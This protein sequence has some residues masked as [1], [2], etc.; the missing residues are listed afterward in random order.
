MKKLTA[1]I[2]PVVLLAV[3]CA[4]Q[5]QVSEQTTTDTSAPATATTTTTPAAYDANM[6]FGPDKVVELKQP[7]SNKVIIKLMF[8][9]GSMVDP[10]GKEGLTYATARMITE[11]GTKDMTVSQ[12]KDKIFPWA[13]DYYTNVDKEVTVFTFAVHKDFLNEFYPI[14]RG[15]MLNPAFAEADFKRVKANQL[16][17]VDQV[18]RASSDEEYSKKAL[19]D[20]LFR[21]TNY[22]HMV[23]GKTASVQNITL[24]DVKNHWRNYFTKNNL[25][26]GIAG[27]YSTDFLNKLKADMAQL[28]D[29]KPNIPQAGNPNKPN[30]IQVEII[31]KSDALGSAIFTGAPMP[32]TRSADDFAALM[33]ANSFLGEHRK[34]YGK[35][36]DKIRTTRSM[37]YGDYSYIE[38]YDNG[39]SFQLPNPGVP[40]TSNY[41][42]LW[43]RP[44]QIAEGLQKQY[45]ELKDIDVGHAHFAT[46]LAVREVDNL[47]KNGMTQEEFELTRKFLR[48]YIKL[49]IQTQEKQLGYLMDS[50]FYG[51]QDYIQELDRLLAN[52]TVQEVNNAVKKYWQTENMFITIVT[53]D[54]EA[55]PLK[56]ALLNNTPSPMSYSNLVR[57]GLPQEVIAEDDKIANYKLNVKDVKIVDSKETFK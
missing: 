21:G 6:A 49:Y 50:R 47:I 54:S 17:F 12:I 36:Y 44:V 40:R 39:G 18:I 10:A 23:E 4:K 51:R 1:Y 52:L 34:S 8:K 3:A 5:P 48:S 24:E 45:A 25:L 53:D 14:V 57:E 43:I 9:N 22:Q 46:R 27:N 29:V 13:A 15:L 31:K 35:L 2:L 41:F 7:E 30:G 42:A 16:N 38:W 19:E 20:L 55:E 33:V 32:V 28:S 26:I 56:Q 37:N 11:S